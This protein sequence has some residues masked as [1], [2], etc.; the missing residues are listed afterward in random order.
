MTKILTVV[1]LLF[2][3][4]PAYGHSA[5]DLYKQSLEFLK[6][7]NDPS[8]LWYRH[9][10]YQGYVRATWDEMDR[11]TPEAV[12]LSQIT[13]VVAKYLREHPED[14]HDPANSIVKRAINEAFPCN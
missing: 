8:R 13:L 4:S 12:N 3:V 5:G 11:C 6:P 14:H 2:L 1:V 10:F 9:G 7:E